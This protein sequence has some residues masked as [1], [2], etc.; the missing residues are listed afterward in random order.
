MSEQCIVNEFPEM[1][2][3]SLSHIKIL[4]YKPYIGKLIL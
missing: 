3:V 4:L 2:R 1:K